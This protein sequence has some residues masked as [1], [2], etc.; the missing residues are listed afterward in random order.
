MA[1]NPP[2]KSPPVIAPAM[3][4]TGAMACKQEDDDDDGTVDVELVVVVVVVF[5]YGEDG[6]FCRRIL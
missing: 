2:A 5:V 1:C 6:L 3:A 4:P